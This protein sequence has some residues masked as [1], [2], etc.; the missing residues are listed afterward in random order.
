MVVGNMFANFVQVFLSFCQGLNNSFMSA[1]RLLYLYAGSFTKKGKKLQIKN[2]KLHIVTDI[3]VN[4]N[5][6]L[7]FRI[8]LFG[9]GEGLL[10]TK[11]NDSSD[12]GVSCDDPHAYHAW[13][14]VRNYPEIIPISRNPSIELQVRNIN[15]SPTPCGA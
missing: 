11:E 13:P 1:T 4:F 7:G 10:Y 12:F 6:M 15:I 5:S 8:S 9:W 2:I 14:E 3:K